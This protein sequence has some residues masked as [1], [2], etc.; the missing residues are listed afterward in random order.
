MTVAVRGNL[1]EFV[2][3][4]SI[5]NVGV[6]GAAAVSK[7]KKKTGF[8]WGFQWGKVV[9]GALMLLIGG[10]IS[11]ALWQG[12]R[13]SIWAVVVA[14]VGLFTMLSGLMGEEGVW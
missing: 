6:L 3:W 4:C 5:F 11:F 7:K 9:T 8:R 13:V 2:G 10:G 1:A 12:G 14:V